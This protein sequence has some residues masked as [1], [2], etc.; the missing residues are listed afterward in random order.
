MAEQQKLTLAQQ[1][2]LDRERD[3]R[4]RA[5]EERRGG[6][7]T[8]QRPVNTPKPDRGA[9]YKKGGSVKFSASLRA[10]GV[11]VK[12]KTKGRFV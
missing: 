4:I 5:E 9:N 2:A 10:D 3:R 12:G 1:E 6:A 7:P 11:A 8:P